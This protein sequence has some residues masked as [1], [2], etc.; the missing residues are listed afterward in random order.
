MRGQQ[1]RGDPDPYAGCDV[2]G[3]VNAGMHARVGNG[4][5]ERNENGRQYRQF[6]AG[7]C[8]ERERRGGVAGWE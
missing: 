2:A 5:R 6:G 7:A 8:G 1:T 4:A 3:V